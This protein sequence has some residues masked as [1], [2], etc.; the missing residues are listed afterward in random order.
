ML[1]NDSSWNQP[2]AE[3]RLG[4][5]AGIDITVDTPTLF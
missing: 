3:P 2:E 5:N 1:R 4:F